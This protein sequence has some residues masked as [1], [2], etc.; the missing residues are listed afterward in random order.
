MF[1][2]LCGIC[3]ST[4]HPTEAHPTLKES[5]ENIRQQSI[6][7]I[8]QEKQNHNEDKSPWNR[9]D[10]PLDY[11]DFHDAEGKLFK[12]VN[13][14]DQEYKEQLGSLIGIEL[15]G[16][17]SQLFEDLNEA[18]RFKKSLGVTLV[19]FRDGE[20]KKADQA[21]NHEVL[22]ANIFSSGFI[23]AGQRYP[24]FE[25]VQKWVKRNGKA[26]FIIEHMSG[27][28]D[29]LDLS[30]ELVF[31]FCLKR[32]YELLGE[33]GTMFVQTPFRLEE[34]FPDGLEKAL[35]KVNVE[36]GYFRGK[37]MKIRRH[38]GSPDNL[39]EVLKDLKE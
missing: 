10:S 33:S 39:N 17:G 12:V 13:Y 34:R 11:Y 28:I 22:E 4:Q 29:N 15:G 32:W 5:L 37:H 23:E 14:L 8:N 36:L 26:N 6:S 1:K 35:S 3:G 38:D 20:R 9:Y 27:P 16:P 2:Y 30:D 7:Y 25:E 31:Q 21:N 24:G 19:D 18:P